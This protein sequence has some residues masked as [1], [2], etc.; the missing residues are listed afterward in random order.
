MKIIFLNRFFYP[1]HSATSQLLT[2]LAFHL[3]DAGWDVSVICSRQRY[4]D[5]AA[6]LPVTEQV[7]RVQV[8]RIWTSRFGRHNLIGR[9]LDYLS[10]Y[11]SAAWRLYCLTREGDIVVA[12]TDPPMISVVAGWIARLRR[13]YLVNWLQDLFPEVATALKI[14]GLDGALG[15]IL[16][17]LRNRSLQQAK[18]N[19][20]LGELMRQRLVAE[21]I[22]E[23]QIRVVHNWADGEAITP[24]PQAQNPLRREWGLEGKF[25]VGYSGNLGRAHEFTTLLDAAES[26]QKQK[27]IVFLFIGGGPQLAKVQEV[28]QSRG[29]GNCVF[30]PYQPRERLRESL[31]VADLHLVVLRPELE[32]LIVPSK[33]YG[34]AAAGRPTIYVGD[35]QGE[36]AQI[37]TRGDAGIAVVIGNGTGLAEQIVELHQNAGCCAG[38]GQNAHLLFEKRYSR[39]LALQAWCTVLNACGR[40][41]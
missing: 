37:V 6:E 10:F 26:L 5:A 32:G 31:G 38:L 15:R 33:F 9:G 35:P 28:V 29:L 12:K 30:R 19:I 21:G 39:Q 14:K 4:D 18:C 2:D 25:V 27:Q 23:G 1:D 16:V 20:V 17:R 7:N 3:A 13:A 8:Y 40:K 41:P 11:L 34:I 22:P 36:V 24:L